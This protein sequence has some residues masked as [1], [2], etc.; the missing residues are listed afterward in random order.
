MKGFMNRVTSGL[1]CLLLVSFLLIA[2]PLPAADLDRETDR[3]PPTVKKFQF[4]ELE[5]PVE[6]LVPKKAPEASE[7][8]RLDAMAWFASGRILQHRGN[9][10]G[11][12]NAYRKAVERD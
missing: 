10:E 12:F 9:Y 2:P 6:V 11:A 7:E 3:P 8:A 4:Q 5:D 1:A